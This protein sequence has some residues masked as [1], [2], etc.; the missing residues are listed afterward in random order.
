MGIVQ[1]S[2]T[3]WDNL[4][5]ALSEYRGCSLVSNIDDP[6]TPSK[7]RERELKIVV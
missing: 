4:L 6:L 5:S 7:L 3:I 2:F 1:A